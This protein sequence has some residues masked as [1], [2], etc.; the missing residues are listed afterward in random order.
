MIKNLLNLFFPKACLGCQNYL[1]DN[2]IYICTSC[3][4]ELPV[5]NFHFDD[6]DTIKKVLY[7]RVKLEHATALLHFSK[8]GIV[9]Q[10]MHNLK[11]RGYEDIGLFLGQWLGAELKTINGYNTIDVVVPVPLHK[12]KFRK[13]GYNQVTKFGASIAEDLDAEFN[14]STLIKTAATRT[15]VFKSRLKR[16]SDNDAIFAISEQQNL[17]GKHILLVDDIITT[18]ATIEHCVN[19]L[20]V[21]E[22]VKISVATMAITD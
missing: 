21:I 1:N 10:L 11:Y 4:H 13:R 2:E 22:G 18:G 7:G 14:S 16:S 15:Q 5:T 8:K 6:N 9:Q 12:S 3:R 19:A 17:K 20:L